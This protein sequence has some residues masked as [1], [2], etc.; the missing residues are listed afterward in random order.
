MT[1]PAATTT[2]L[3]QAGI[4]S[5]AIATLT[6]RYDALPSSEQQWL[7]RLIA[8]R[9]DEVLRRSFGDGTSDAVDT[10]GLAAAHD[11]DPE[12]ETFIP[13]RL[14]DT[15][16]Q[17]SF[18]SPG[19]ARAFAGVMST[20]RR[21]HRSTCVAMVGDSTGDGYLVGA[22]GTQVNEWPQV[23]MK[24]LAADYPAYTLHE[25]RWND[26]AQGYDPYIEWQAG[27]G[28]GGGERAAVFSKT[29]GGSLQYQGAA[30]TAALDVQVRIA[31]TTW[32]PTGDQC[33]AAKW[34]SGANQR[35][36]LF[37][38]KTTGALGLNWSTAGTAGAGE[39]VSTVTIPATANPGNGN[40]L[41]V[42]AT[43][44]LDNAAAGNDVRFYYST[45][46][47]TWTQLGTTVTTAGVTSLFGGT[48]AY[49]IGAFA[50]G[51]SSPFD[52][53]VY[54]TRVY[55]TIGGRQ[56]LVPPLPDDW[57]WYPSSPETAVSFAG[58]PVLTLLNGSQ[59]GQ[60]VAY[61]DNATRRPIIHQ[62]HGQAVVM[63]NTGHNDATQSR[64]L[65]LTNYN[66]MV[67]NIKTL[68]PYVP[69]LAVAENPVGSGGSFA[70]TAQGRELRASRGAI[71]Q[72]WAASQ[73]GVYAFD[74]WPLLT[75]ADTIDQLHPTTG[76]GS[77][78]E[79]WGLALY[80]R[81]KTM[82]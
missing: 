31:P 25:R 66:A 73:A 77:G 22:P 10:G 62:P 48:A 29:T 37:M 24:K 78:S 28:N 50:T 15:A 57:D 30:A 21:G 45:D 38:L 64:Q 2:R 65:W 5:A 63:V 6:A 40:P 72:Q 13:A 14:S 41:W 32:T 18:G 47:I 59:S 20:L 67:T 16:L 58:A 26:T 12:R 61:L 19:P 53:K 68:L 55:G 54:R 44:T 51:L 23:L 52:G 82:T 33:I 80:N 27:T 79:K 9:P 4:S 46:G 81:I 76:T 36:F 17:G 42:R 8:S 11:T 75:A 49:Q 43:L 7:R 3:R 74:A 34:D 70:I 1:L 35:S 69:V 60:G 39:K 56:S 71:L